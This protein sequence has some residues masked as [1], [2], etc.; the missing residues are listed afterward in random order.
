MKIILIKDTFDF[1]V[2]ICFQRKTMKAR[3]KRLHSGPE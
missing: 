3:Y 1:N 2:I